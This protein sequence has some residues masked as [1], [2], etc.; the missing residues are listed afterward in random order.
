MNYRN[1]Q[2]AVLGAGRSGLAAARLAA[3]EG[4]RPV[5]YDTG[6]SAKLRATAG[7]LAGE[8]IASVLGAEALS[9]PVTADLVVLSPG[10]DASWDLPR[11]FAGAGVRIIGETEFAHTLGTVPVI[12]I[13]GTNGKTTTTEL[14]ARLLS[15][16]GQRTVACGNYGVPYS[17][18]L[19]SGEVYDVLTMEISSFQCETIETF[20]CPITV[21]LNFAADHL[22][23]YPGV[24]EY[25]AAKMRIFENQTAEDVAVVDARDPMPALAARKVTFSA[26][27]SSADYTLS[28]GTILFQG[29]PVADFRATRLRGTHN[30][31]NLMAA[32]A[33]GRERGLGYGAMMAA[34]AEYVPPRHRCEFIA[35]VDGCDYINDSKATNL[36]ALASSLVA[37]GE[38]VV[39]IAGGKQKGLPF[40]ELRETVA[41][42]A[43]HVVLIGEIR[44]QVRGRWAEGAPCELADSV[45]EAVALARKA[46]RPGQT[47]LFSP[48]TS[49][50]DMFSGYEERGDAFRNAVIK[51][52]REIP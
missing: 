38:N 20:R 2:I 19:L 46:A 7:Q 43:S 26:F 23:R 44:E 52:N 31:E 35:T 3:R 12:G 36:H 50:F 4:A 49:S 11:R 34:A 18:V 37:M 30:A 32:L 21:W 5:V 39:L 28:G 33:V 42:H 14:I 6:D 15:A 25:R 10:I 8:G 1:Q 48:G 16:N 24:E 29:E 47:V 22:D 13:T 51:L 27:D 40:E 17:E 45:D 9:S 41:R